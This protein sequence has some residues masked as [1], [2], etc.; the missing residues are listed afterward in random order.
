MGS[1]V[2]AVL[3]GPVIYLL[4]MAKSARRMIPSRTEVVRPS[5]SAAAC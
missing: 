4:S 1:H 2:V 3:A 5:P